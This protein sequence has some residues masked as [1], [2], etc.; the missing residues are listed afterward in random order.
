MKS[1][2]ESPWRP[3]GEHRQAVGSAVS[4][5]AVAGRTASAGV[6]AATLAPPA[7]RRLLQGAGLG[8]GLAALAL[9]PSAARART[10]MARARAE[11]QPAPVVWRCQM[12]W[13]LEDDFHAYITTLAEV[14]GTMTEGRLQLEVLPALSLIHI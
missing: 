1:G 8:A 2:F 11:S 10:A 7:R 9:G 13:T 14:L 6:P 12:A 4:G 5:T 3:A